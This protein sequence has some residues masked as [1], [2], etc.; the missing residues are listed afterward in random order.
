MAAFSASGFEMSPTRAFRPSRGGSFA[1]VTLV[2]ATPSAAAMMMI[3]DVLILNAV[4]LG[5]GPAACSRASTV[6]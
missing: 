4:F 6:T 3:F 2:A 5:V 1:S